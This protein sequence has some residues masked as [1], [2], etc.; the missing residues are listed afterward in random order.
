MDQTSLYC[1]FLRRTNV[2]K[3]NAFANPELIVDKP[4]N[5]YLG[6]LVEFGFVGLLLYLIWVGGVL[7]KAR[8]NIIIVSAVSILVAFLFYDISITTGW[9]LIT[10]LGILSGDVVKMTSLEEG[11]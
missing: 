10:S 5:Q 9:L 4:H 1:H 11:M 2:S 7:W 8:K 3:L 6:F